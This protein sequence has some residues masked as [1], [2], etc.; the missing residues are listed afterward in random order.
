MLVACLLQLPSCS[1]DGGLVWQPVRELNGRPKDHAWEHL[2]QGHHALEL[3]NLAM[4]R[5]FYMD[6]FETVSFDYRPSLHLD[7]IEGLIAIDSA[8]GASLEKFKIHLEAILNGD[9]LSGSSLV[10]DGKVRSLYEQCGGNAYPYP[11]PRPIRKEWWWDISDTDE[12]TLERNRLNRMVELPLFF[13]H[14]SLYWPEMHFEA[15]WS[16]IRARQKLG[17]PPF[18]AELTGDVVKLSG[19]HEVWMGAS[20]SGPVRNGLAHG[21]WTLWHDG[22]QILARGK[23]KQGQRVGEWIWQAVDP[24]YRGELNYLND[25]RH[26]PSWEWAGEGHLFTSGEYANGCK[27]GIWKRFDKDG[28]EIDAFIYE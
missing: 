11:R 3:G 5:E 28:Q 20:A 15:V 19:E 8:N 23:C 9:Q 16:A 4:A 12:S 25:E 13:D 2:Q 22:G 1:D 6:L 24:T 18:D 21:V 10:F 26:G 14:H 27:I 7:A 17:Q